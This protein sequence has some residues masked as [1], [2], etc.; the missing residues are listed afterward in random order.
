[1]VQLNTACCCAFRAQATRE[2]AL[3]RRA[4]LLIVH[5]PDSQEGFQLLV[6]ALQHP[7]LVAA[8]GG[9]GLQECSLDWDPDG[10]EYEVSF[11]LMSRVMWLGPSRLMSWHGVA[12][13]AG[14][15]SGQ[16][17][18]LAYCAL[19][20]KCFDCWLQHHVSHV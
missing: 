20:S 14:T 11:L 6:Q 17:C 7:W 10:N 19:S 9:E 12:G 5:D 3:C 8:E 2:Q 18:R 1:M 15:G 16:G 4:L 13:D